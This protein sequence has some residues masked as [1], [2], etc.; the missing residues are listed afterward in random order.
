MY[1]ARKDQPENG[2]SF[3]D[4]RATINAAQGYK[5]YHFQSYDYDS[6]SCGGFGSGS[7][8]YSEGIS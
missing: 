7:G 5:R 8:W 4:N 1:R 2:I 3:T 6:H